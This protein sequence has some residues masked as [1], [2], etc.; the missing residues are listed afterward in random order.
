MADKV[1]ATEIYP[2]VE[3]AFSDKKNIN[4]FE[5]I[6]ASFVDRN[7]ELLS[8]SG[9]TKI[10]LF[11]DYEKKAVY[12]LIDIDQKK[13]K[14]A[15]NKSKDIK[16]SGRNMADPFK[17]LMSMIV[18][19]FSI[20][21]NPKITRLAVFYT[22]CALYPSLFS[23]Y[24]KFQP[25]EKVMEYT[26]NNLSNKYKIKQLGNLMAVIDDLAFGA[27]ELHR[28][29]LDAGLDSGVVL[30]I[31]SIQ[32]RMNSFLKQISNE[33][34]A[35]YQSGKYLESEFES[36]DKDN[37]REAESSMYA[38]NQ[39]VDR[40]SLRLVIDGPP[41]RIVTLSANNNQVSVNELRNYLNLMIV[42]DNIDEI[43][44]ILEAIL[45]LFLYDEHNASKDINSDK[46]LIYCLDT[47]KRS[48][49]TNK[50][51]VEIKKILD[52]WLERLDVYKK[53]QRLATINAFRR[54]LYM[55]FVLS[56]QYYN[57]R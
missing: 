41:M 17:C 40:V 25:N 52:G 42:N 38:V 7:H 18:R 44:K 45:V 35:N 3:K 31:L 13:I 27:Y 24:W 22:G 20:N 43:K 5:S 10:I 36:N 12:D 2:Y 47:Y 37:F 15:K 49:T 23:K 4:K 50:N 51:I 29:K 57:S 32:A 21:N 19:Y 54:A 8:A 30:F 6:I 11:T 39:I 33:W 56:I 9:P 46:F 28:D 26:I 14:D 1:L 16:N 55:F 34:Y 48:N 53:T